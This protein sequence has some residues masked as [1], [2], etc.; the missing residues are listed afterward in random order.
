MPDSTYVPPSS[1]AHIHLG[2][3]EVDAFF[4]SMDRAIDERDHMVM[5]IK[6]YPFLDPVRND[7]RYIA[8]LQKMNLR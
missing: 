8:L 2:L 1:I 5:P 4:E 3:G 6:T 7:S